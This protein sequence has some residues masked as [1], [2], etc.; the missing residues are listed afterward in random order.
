MHVYGKYYEFVLKT[1]VCTWQILCDH[2]QELGNSVAFSCTELDLVLSKVGK[3]E[4]WIK[5]CI[6]IVGTSIG[7]EKSLLDALWK[8]LI[9]ICYSFSSIMRVWWKL[10]LFGYVCV[11]Y[12]LI[13]FIAQIK[14]DLDRSLYIYETSRA[15]KARNLCICCSSDAEDLVLLT[16][17]ICKDW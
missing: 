16:C 3:I 1:N 11:W 4:K 12:F 17:S 8:V 10:W 5:R 6:D 9:C 14:K 7:D 15:C 2:L 13:I